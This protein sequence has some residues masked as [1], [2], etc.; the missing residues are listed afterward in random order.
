MKKKYVLI[1]YALN[2]K[3][4]LQRNFYTRLYRYAAIIP[5]NT[6]SHKRDII[7]LRSY[8]TTIGFH[9]TISHKVYTWG[10]GYYSPTTS[11]QITMYCHEH[12]CT[13]VDIDKMTIDEFSKKYLKD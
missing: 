6:I 13:R 8:D 5:A 10:Y 2:Y 11:K 3:R 4:Y 1:S 9:D 7:A 12:N